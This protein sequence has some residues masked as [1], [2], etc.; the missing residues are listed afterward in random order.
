MKPRPTGPLIT[1]MPIAAPLPALPFQLQ[2]WT[3]YDW[4]RTRDE[5]GEIDLGTCPYFARYMG[6]Q[7][8]DPQAVCYQMSVCE[9]AGEPLCVTDEPR[10][11]W[12]SMREHRL[13][14]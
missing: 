4:V 1:E 12:P 11:G 3:I 10:G 6:L 14:R 9:R 7:G 8:H 13:K 2:L 5:D